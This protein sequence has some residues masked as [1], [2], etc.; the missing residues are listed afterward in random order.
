MVVELDGRRW[1]TTAQAQTEDR[2]RDR[3]ATTHGWVTLR[4]GWAEVVHRPAAVVDECRA[5][6]AARGAEQAPDAGAG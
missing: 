3:L 1:H 6:L 2:R 5:V 4:F